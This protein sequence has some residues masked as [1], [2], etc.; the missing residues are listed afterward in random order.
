MKPFLVLALAALLL[1]LFIGCQSDAPVTP[2]DESSSGSASALQKKGGA[3]EL[4]PTLSV[5]GYRATVTWNAMEGA[6]SYTVFL[7]G[8]QEEVVNPYTDFPISGFSEVKKTACTLSAFSAQTFQYYYVE[9]RWNIGGLM[10]GYATSNFAQN[11]NGIT[12]SSLTLGQ[13]DDPAP[14]VENQIVAH[15]AWTPIEGAKGYNIFWA[16]TFGDP[17]TA[18]GTSVAAKVSSYDAGLTVYATGEPL[19]RTTDLTTLDISVRATD[20]KGN[21]ITISTVTLP[22]PEVLTTP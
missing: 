15:L 21:E 9:V 7:Y 8:C 14:I 10:M 4:Q 12:S 22:C 17:A 2:V 13:A 6:T 1:T 3:T 5:L 20:G 19:L 11:Q 18:G 16:Q